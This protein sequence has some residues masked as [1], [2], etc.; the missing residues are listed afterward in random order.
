MWPLMKKLHLSWM[1][2]TPDDSHFYFQFQS[3]AKRTEALGLAAQQ[4]I[5]SLLFVED[6]ETKTSVLPCRGTLLDTVVVME[7]LQPCLLHFPTLAEHLVQA[8]L[9]N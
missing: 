7:M 4:T 1:R 9:V 8:I 2:V 5:D 6:D 3:I